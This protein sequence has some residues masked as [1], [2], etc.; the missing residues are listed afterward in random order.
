MSTRE[1]LR[2]KIA[3]QRNAR[4]G[5]VTIAKEYS[6]WQQPSSQGVRKFRQEEEFGP[7]MRRKPWRTGT[8]SQQQPAPKGYAKGY[9]NQPNQP[10]RK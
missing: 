2:A 9:R 1:R 3:E 5:G 10:K 7:K 6:N 8:K 4:T